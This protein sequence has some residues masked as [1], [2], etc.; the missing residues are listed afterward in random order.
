MES[1]I[2][3]P[4]FT[5]QWHVFT[6]GDK[7]SHLAALHFVL[8]SLSFHWTGTEG[9]CEHVSLA[10]FPVGNKRQFENKKL[11]CFHFEHLSHRHKNY[12]PAQPNIRTKLRPLLSCSVRVWSNSWHSS[13]CVLCI[14]VHVLLHF[15]SLDSKQ[16]INCGLDEKLNLWQLKLN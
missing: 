6:P 15:F 7:Y 3:A 10:H 16:N 13:S 2:S 14:A 4:C 5:P 12:S 1:F 8:A 11:E 9:H